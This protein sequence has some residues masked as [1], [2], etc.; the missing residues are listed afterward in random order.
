MASVLAMEDE[1]QHSAWLSDDAEYDTADSSWDIDAKP[2]GIDPTRG[3]DNHIDGHASRY[4]TSR[5]DDRGS[6]ESAS[7]ED[8]DEEEDAP[9]DANEDS[10]PSNLSSADDEQLEDADLEMEDQ[11]DSDAEGD[12]ELEQGVEDIRLKE[13][14]SDEEDELNSGDSDLQ[15]SHEEEF[16]EDEADEDVDDED[17]EVW[18]EAGGVEDEESDDELPPH[19]C[20]FCKQDEEKD[21]G[22][23]DEAYIACTGCGEHGA[24]SASL[25]PSYIRWD[26]LADNR[27]STPTM[28]TRCLC[29][30][31]A[32]PYVQ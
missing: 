10:P 23:D 6:D 4:L 11:G 20:L 19:S 31:S 9:G 8:M 24:S 30:Q 1:L 3:L 13:G 5:Q 14:E 22:E 15:T 28:R 2:A 7:A 27:R 25:S 26:G 29:N 17:E 16:D 12:A 32:K 18:E 21:A